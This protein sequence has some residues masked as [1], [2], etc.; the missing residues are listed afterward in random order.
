M[1]KLIKFIQALYRQN[2]VFFE[3]MEYLTFFALMIFLLFYF[4]PYI[5]QK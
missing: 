1:K 3:F 4:Y 5:L 2:I